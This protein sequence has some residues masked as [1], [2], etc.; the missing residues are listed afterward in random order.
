MANGGQ[1]LVDYA[2]FD[3]IK[4]HRDLAAIDSRGYNDKRLVETAGAPSLACCSCKCAGFAGR[5]LAAAG[6]WW[7]CF[8]L[9]LSLI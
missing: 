5:L 8:V 2:T 1:V 4:D 9:Q 6:C 7:F 3:E